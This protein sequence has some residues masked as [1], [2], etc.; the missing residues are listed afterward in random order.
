MA[1]IGLLLVGAIIIVSILRDRLVNQPQ[2]QVQVAGQGK[3]AYQP[4]IANVTVGVQVDK[5][6]SAESALRQLNDKVGKVLQS[7]KALGVATADIETQNYTLYPQYDYRNNV[8]TLAGYNANQQL[9]I[10]VRGLSSPSDAKVSQVIAEATKA[11]ANQ[12]TGVAF[13][14]SNL[15]DLKQQ[16]RLKAIADAKSKAGS[17]AQAIGVRLGH[18]VG[19][20]ENVVQAPGV[21]Y[22]GGVGGGEAKGAGAGMSPQVPSGSQEVIVEVNLSYKIR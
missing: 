20:W 17:L 7:L 2:W 18:V 14:V 19:W 6:A 4:D 5:A 3:V 16:A 10:E 12:V 21:Q 1:L 9:T 15:N 22:G 13:D 8:S 11:G